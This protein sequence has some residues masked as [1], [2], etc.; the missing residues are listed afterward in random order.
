MILKKALIVFPHDAMG[1]AERVTRSVAYSA[2]Q[3]GTFDEV[4]CFVLSRG[5]TS[6][7]KSLSMLPGA[8]IVYSSA[9][10]MAKGIPDLVRVCRKERYDFTF[11]SFVD[12][13]AILC[14]LRRLGILRTKRLVTRES[15]MMFERDFGWKT[16]IVRLLYQFYGR[17]D[18]IVCQTD[19]MAIS[20]TENTGG[21]YRN[22]T[23]VIPNP[24]DFEVTL[25][26]E[27]PVGGALY[28][29]PE[30]KERIV[31]C[32]RMVPVK[33]PLRAIETLAE[34]HAAGIDESHLV[35]IGEGPMR[36]EIEALVKKLKLSD[37]VTLTG[38][39]SLPVALMRGCRAGLVTSEVEGF[40][41]VILEM[42]YAGVSG[43]ATTNC[44][45]GLAEV[46]GIAIAGENTPA[47][48]AGVLS[49]ILQRASP[50][51]EIEHFLEARQPQIFF[52]ALTNDR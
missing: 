9:G 21:R 49:E 1:G 51:A 25:A 26:R 20:L 7:L 43:V 11:C 29:I 13:N 45:G 23:S 28:E 32:G 22:I 33:S 30:K 46:P 24:V 48:L 42:L 34:L 41:N 31:W 18:L 15:T 3:S 2:L 38:F 16:P 50:Q 19:R 39:Q 47:V 35:M 37:H 52:S 10:R 6:T 12:L 40:P 27:V 44:A 4:T 5:N 17:Q 14:G 36:A 8:R